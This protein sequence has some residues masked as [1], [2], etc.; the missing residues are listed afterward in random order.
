MILKIDPSGK[1]TQLYVFCPQNDCSK[2]GQPSSSLT[3]DMSGHLIGTAFY[4]GV[5]GEGVVFELAP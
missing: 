3:A 5:Y 4:G 1:E 2:G